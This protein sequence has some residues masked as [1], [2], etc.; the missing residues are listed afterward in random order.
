MSSST[1]NIDDNA[2]YDIAPNDELTILVVGAC[3]LDRS[4]VV[5]CYPMEDSKV[6]ATVYREGGGGNASNTAAALAKISSSSKFAAN[7]CKNKRIRVKLISKVGSDPMGYQLRS[8]LEERQNV[9]VSFLVHKL[10]TTTSHTTVIVSSKHNTRTCIH[11]P[12]TCGE[13]TSLEEELLPCSFDDIFH[14]VVWVHF[15]TRHTDF[16]L[17]LAREAQRRN[18]SNISVDIEKDRGS[19]MTELINIA[20]TLFTSVTHLPSLL[21]RT[22][23]SYTSKENN[24]NNTLSGS[25]NNH[26]NILCKATMLCHHFCHK[27]GQFHKEVIV[28]NGE[29]GSFHVKHTATTGNNTFVVNEEI[30]ETSPCTIAYDAMNQTTTLYERRVVEAAEGVS[31]AETIPHYKIHKAGSLRNI[32]V[33][34]TTGAGDCFIAGFILSSVLWKAATDSHSHNSNGQFS[35]EDLALRMGSWVAGKKIGGLGS[36]TSLPIGKDLDA[37]LGTTDFVTVWNAL[38]KIVF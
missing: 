14:N 3:T 11:Y 36:R 5:P 8:E 12:G 22:I 27:L 37:E 34:D 33:V 29:K 20:T 13:L 38:K 1:T 2:C 9:D 32:N 31:V 25:N 21:E 23:K 19:A 17:C 4:L 30:V 6:R 7:I 24:D 10:E 35:M 26:Q 28:T 18:I 15:D 16:S